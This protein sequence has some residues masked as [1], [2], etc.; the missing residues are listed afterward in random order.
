MAKFTV[1]RGSSQY[2]TYTGLGFGAALL[3]LVLLPIVTSDFITFQFT[4]ALLWSMGV[5]SLNMLTGWSGQ[6]SLPK[7]ALLALRCNAPVLPV[8][9]RLNYSL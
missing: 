7:P 1:V 6:I 2:R 4:M 5:L 9:H 3:V 8:L